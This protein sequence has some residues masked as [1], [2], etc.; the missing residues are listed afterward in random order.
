MYQDIFN[1]RRTVL[2]NTFRGSP[3]YWQLEKR[4]VGKK[5]CGL[6]A[7]RKKG[8][9]FKGIDTIGIQTFGMSIKKACI[10]IKCT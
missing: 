2:G 6:K 10:G 7:F 8:M 1:C 9:W 4:H 5:A 3:V